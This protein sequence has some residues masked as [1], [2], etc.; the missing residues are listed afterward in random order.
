M[1]R[2]CEIFISDLV[3]VSPRLKDACNDVFDYWRPDHPPLTTLYSALGRQISDDF[4]SQE[5]NVN[6]QIFFLIEAAM[7]SDD[8]ELVTAV[9]TGL[10]EAMA[11]H[12][13][14]QEDKWKRIKMALGERSLQHAK[15]W[16]NE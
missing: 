11:V 2:K 15:V 10:I 5:S 16:M 12:A 6:D 4:F 14:S 7:C 8:E 13:A 1:N 9:A 3:D